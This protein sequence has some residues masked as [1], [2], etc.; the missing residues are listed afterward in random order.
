VSLRRLVDILVSAMGLVI[1][2]P[3]LLLLALLIAGADG[4]PVL[5][6]QRRATLRGRPFRLVKFRTMTQRC[7]ADGSLLPDALRITPLGRWLRSTRFDELPQLWNVL[8]GEMSLIGP[9]PLLP[10]TIAG[11]GQ[12]GVLRCAVRPGMTGWA[13][14]NG[15]ALL[16]DADKIALDLWYLEHRS[17]ALD[18]RVLLGTL[19][20]MWGRE[21]AD[22]LAIRRAYESHSRR[23]G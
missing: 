10:E 19:R 20:V 1:A 15:N 12:R 7:A 6:R 14:I 4:R 9:R 16:D 8:K 22:P 5:F 13:Q 21:R 11:A 2:L 3:V 18:V 23:G 17:F